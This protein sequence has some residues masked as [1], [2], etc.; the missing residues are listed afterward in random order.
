MRR[1]ATALLLALGMLS[2]ASLGCIGHM[3]LS[4]K[5][6]KFNLETTEDRWGREILWHGRYQP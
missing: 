6:K 1:R 2:I 3:G 5:V 4:Q